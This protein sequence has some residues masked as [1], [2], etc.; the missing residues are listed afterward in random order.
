MSNS[1]PSD[2][3]LAT[4]SGVPGIIDYLADKPA[5]ETPGP[6]LNCACD[7]AGFNEMLKM[8]LDNVKAILAAD[9]YCLML[10]DYKDDDEFDEDA[11][12]LMQVSA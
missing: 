7:K 2:E 6:L 5:G 3:V 9:V 10:A 11:G 1:W 8:E 4:C 12:A